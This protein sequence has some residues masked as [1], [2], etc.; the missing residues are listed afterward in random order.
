MVI[1]NTVNETLLN[2]PWDISL[3][4]GL[5][6]IIKGTSG[7]IPALAGG[8]EITVRSGTIFGIGKVTLTMIAGDATRT[9]TGFV[10]G[11]FLLG[12]Q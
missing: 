6:L 9:A 5:L 1:R 10:L 11:P 2:I 12:V 4:G 3:K 7:I 8:A